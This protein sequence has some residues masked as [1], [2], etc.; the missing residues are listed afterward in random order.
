MYRKVFSVSFS[1]AYLAVNAQFFGASADGRHL[2]EHSQVVLIA[3]SANK[4]TLQIF[5][6]SFSVNRNL[7]RGALRS[8]GLAFFELG[9]LKIK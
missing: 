9:G 2:F 1:T 3:G 6:N 4:G 5:N 7:S 8:E